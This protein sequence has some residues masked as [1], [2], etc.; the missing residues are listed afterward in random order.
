MNQGKALTSVQTQV[1]LVNDNVKMID[2]RIGRNE[3]KMSEQSSTLQEIKDMLCMLTFRNASSSG[4]ILPKVLQENPLLT[5]SMNLVEGG[6]SPFIKFYVAG[7]YPM[8]TWCGTVCI[9][10]V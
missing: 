7:W 3:T 1:S 6:T 5:K 10:N 2:Q 9:V 4:S 8:T